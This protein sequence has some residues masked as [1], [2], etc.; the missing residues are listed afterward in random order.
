V[1]RAASPCFAAASG[2]LIA[3]RA[4]GPCHKKIQPVTIRRATVDDAEAI[5]D[6]HIRSIRVLCAKDYT[7]QQIEAWA[8]RKRTEQYSHAMTDGGETM[9]VAI[10]EADRIAG[11]VAF[12]DSEIYGLYV[13]P[14]SVGRGAG[15]KLLAVAEAATRAAGVAH[16]RFRST[17][18]AVTFYTRQGYVCG[19][20]AISRM[21]GV[22]I[23]CVWMSKTL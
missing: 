18:T 12:K 20:D 1:A 6:V 3:S 11:F 10:D 21:S 9:F 16:V 5:C 7:P 14:E 15:V 2:S 17:L 4:S 23:P 22:E 8:G 19:G 13:A